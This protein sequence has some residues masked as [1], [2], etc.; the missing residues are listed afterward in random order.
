MPHPPHAPHPPRSAADDTVRPAAAGD[1]AAVTAV[2][3]AAWRAAYSGTLG[4][5]ALALLDEA[6][7]EL[8]WR[9]AI[10]SPPGAGF[11]VLVAIAGGQVVG[12]VSIAPVAA[13]A[14]AVD[15]TPGGVLLALEVAPDHQRGGHGSRL[16]AAAVDTLRADGADQVLTWVAD[17]DGPRAQ[18]LAEAGLAP[19]GAVREMASGPGPDGED[20][21]LRERRWFAGI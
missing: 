16:L 1:A 2:Q 14:N 11:H 9:E 4:E 13:P 17:G 7:V 3:L 21:V 15:R 19:D 18:F 20:A 5:G 8:R 6:A 12:F 10:A